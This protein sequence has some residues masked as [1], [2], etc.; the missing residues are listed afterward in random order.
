MD[1]RMTAMLGDRIADVV[2]PAAVSGL[3]Q[4]T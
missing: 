1:P 3:R 2:G 4:R